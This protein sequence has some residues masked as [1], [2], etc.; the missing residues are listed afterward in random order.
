MDGGNKRKKYITTPTR[1][2]ERTKKLSANYRLV[3][4]YGL[5][6]VSPLVTKLKE[7]YNKKYPSNHNEWVV[8]F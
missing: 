5:A 1:K 3:V 2:V 8:V 6:N 4:N 7:K